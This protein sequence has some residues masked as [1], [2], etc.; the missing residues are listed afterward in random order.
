VIQ[1]FYYYFPAYVAN[2]TP[3]LLHGGGSIDRDIKWFDGKP[4]FGNHKTIIGTASG[5]AMGTLLGI[6]QQF[7]LNGFLLSL[8]AVVGDIANSFLKRRLDLKP[9]EPLP[10][11]DQ[12]SFIIL[13]AIL[14]YLVHPKPSVIQTILVIVTTLPIHYL[15]NYIAYTLK[16]KKNPW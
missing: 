5:V 8:G 2:A 16:M 10:V 11:F 13:A 7:P 3:V 9:G 14:G 1:A 15:V 6:L 12:L 4:L